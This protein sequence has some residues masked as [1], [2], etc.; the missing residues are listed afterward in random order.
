MIQENY[1]KQIIIIFNLLSDIWEK[2]NFK[3]KIQF[4]FLCILSVINS[5]AEILSLS[6]IIPFIGLLINSEEFYNTKFIQYLANQLSINNSKIM[7]DFLLILF[8]FIILMSTF[9]KLINVYFNG[10]YAALLGVDF[11]SKAFYK[12]ISQRHLFHLNNNTSKLISSMTSKVDL[13]IEVIGDILQIITSGIVALGLIITLVIF[14]PRFT[15]LIGGGLVLTY[16]L[17]LYKVS[18]RQININSKVIA[19]NLNNQIKLMQEAFGSIIDIILNNNQEKFQKLHYQNEYKLR[20]YKANSIFLTRFPKYLIEGVISIFIGIYGYFLVIND[21][22]GIYILSLLGGLVV[23][24]QK[25]LP[26]LQ[27]IYY[28]YSTILGYFYSVRDLIELNNLEIP[29]ESRLIK[30]NKIKFVLKNNIKFKDISFNYDNKGFNDLNDLNLEIK[31]GEKIGLIGETGA[32]KSTI[33]K[34][35]MGLIIPSEGDILLDNKNLF[36][37]KFPEYFLSWRASIAYVPQSIYLNDASIA[38]N[39][40]SSNLNEEIDYEWVKKCAKIAHIDQFIKTQHDTY[41]HFVGERGTKLS[42]GQLQRIGIARALYKKNTNI[43]ILDEATSALDSKTEDK[44]IKSINNFYK[45]KIIIM[46]SHKLNTLRFCDK[47]F[48]IN[49]GKIEENNDTFNLEKIL[50][51]N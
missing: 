3:R 23:A 41:N 24:V 28:S 14:E 15:L 22:P 50:K 17:I 45:D 5:F 19:N 6:I 13:A 21:F 1:K 18:K 46:V 26:N 37:Y 11:S 43:L 20:T 36:E 25:I 32:G 27:L 42:G 7:T 4:I 8:V 38:E 34:L 47:V 48:K 30:R 12:I 16:F 40:A 33:L 51:N 44:I 9:I 35:I 49:D 39:I 10:R 31:R 29:K 2:I